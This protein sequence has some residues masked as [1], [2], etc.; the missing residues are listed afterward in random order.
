MTPEDR[1]IGKFHQL[2]SMSLDALADSLSVDSRKEILVIVQSCLRKVE[3]PTHA[4]NLSMA[5]WLTQLREN[6]RE[7]TMQMSRLLIAGDEYTAMSTIDQAHHRQEI[8]EFTSI[9]PWVYYVRLM[10]DELV[11]IK[12]SR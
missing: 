12:E 5:N 9:C 11:R 3:F 8:A 6:H 10:N 4:D 2:T 1:L 7:W